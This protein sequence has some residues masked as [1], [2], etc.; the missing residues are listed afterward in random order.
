MNRLVDET[1]FIKVGLREFAY[2]SIE[3]KRL[4]GHLDN[5]CSLLEEEGIHGGGAHDDGCQ[6][7]RAIVDARADLSPQLT[8]REK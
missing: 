5:L 3:T 6:I 2:T 8:N 7:C 4:R 1:D